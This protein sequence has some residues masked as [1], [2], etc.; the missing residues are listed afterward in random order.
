[1]AQSGG[2]P[3]PIPF[4]EFIAATREASLP[5]LQRAPHCRVRDAPAFAE[6]RAH[7]LERYR[8]MAVT[9]SLLVGGHTF[10][11]VAAAGAEAAPPG[12]TSGCP[13][14]TIPMRRMT[15]EEMV[16]FETLRDFLRKGSGRGAPPGD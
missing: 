8:G 7:V 12:T 15:L 14:G 4:A 11:C 9:R 13:P 5:Q 6:M 10:D 1:M 3:G 2:S 16:R